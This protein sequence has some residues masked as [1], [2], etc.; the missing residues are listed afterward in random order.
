M[1][2]S[3]IIKEKNEFSGEPSFPIS[4]GDMAF[5]PKKTKK[6]TEISNLFCNWMNFFFTKQI[7]K[8]KITS[9]LL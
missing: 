6:K 8:K 3:Q 1:T 7:K 9:S 4:Q 5:K 2:N